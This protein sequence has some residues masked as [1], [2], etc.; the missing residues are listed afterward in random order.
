MLRCPWPWDVLEQA[1]DPSTG[2]RA[3]EAEGA[4][5]QV[6]EVTC[7]GDGDAASS[8]LRVRQL[9]I[10]SAGAVTHIKTHEL[11]PLKQSGRVGRS[12]PIGFCLMMHGGFSVLQSP[13]TID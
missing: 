9:E 3:A 13:L 5:R 11:M 2:S 4:S 8:T 7:M 12:L 10:D 1:D 6:A